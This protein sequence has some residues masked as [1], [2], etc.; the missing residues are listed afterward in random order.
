MKAKITNLLARIMLAMGL[1]AGSAQ[2]AAP[3]TPQGLITGKAYLNITGTALS[4]LTNSTKYPDSPDITLFL[5]YFEWNATGDIATAPGDY[6]DNYGA[7]IAGYFY[8]PSTGD[9]YFYI[10]ADDNAVLYLST[11]SNPANKKLIAQETAYSDAR[12][13][14]SSAGGSDITAKD[15]SQFIGSEWPN[16]PDS[17]YAEIT[18]QAG[19]P[20]YIEAVLKEGTGGDHLAVSVL[21]PNAA[22]DYSLPIPGDYLATDRAVGPVTIV[23]QPASQTAVERGSATFSV[24]AN[25]TPPYT[26]QWRKN[27]TDILDATN[28]S[29]TVTSATIVD[30]NAQFSVV[31]TG[32]EG[33]ATSADAVLTVTPETEPP[34][35]LSAQ[36]RP[37]L[38]EV[39][40]TFSEPLDQTSAT[41][42]GNYSIS[43]S[44]GA[45][46]VT[47]VELSGSGTQV[48][49]T[50]DPQTLGTKYTLNVSNVK[51]TAATPNTI[52]ANSKA[53]F[54]P[55]GQVVE[56][57]GF[58]VLEAENFDRNL[59]GL[60]V[61]DSSRG[62]PSGGSSMLIPN[63]T[64]GSDQT[65]R[66][67]YD[68]NFAQAATYHV[69]MRASADNGND[70]SVW[71][72]IDEDDDGVPEL[73]YERASGN[74]ASMTGFQP[75]ADFVWVSDSQDGPDP[76]T[77]DVPAAG[78]RTIAIARREDG[79]FVD[80][81][82]LTTDSAFT[83]SGVGPAETREGAPGL[84]VVTLT[85]PTADQTF[86]PG[87]D[88]TLSATATGQSGLEI[89]R[90]QFSANGSVIGEATNSPFNLVWTN[91]AAGI[92]GIR[93]TAFDEIGQSSISAPVNI[94][95]SASS[96]A[97]IAWVSFHPADDTPSAG[98]ATAGFTN[99]PD[100]LY[101]DLLKQHGDT[102]T[103]VVTSGTPNT[104]LLNAFD[105]VIISR[106]VPSGDYQDPPET[107]AW[108]GITSP[109]MILGGYILRDSRLG[110]T[111]GSTIPDA[112]G[113]VKLTVSDPNHPIFKGITLDAANTMVNN[114]ADLTTFN[115]KTNR[116]ISVNTD[117]IE[118]GGTVLATVGTDTDPAFGGMI[119]GEFPAGSLINGGVDTLGGHRLVFLTGSREYDGL[120]SE[121]AGVFDLSPD[122][123]KM[124]LNAVDYMSGITPEARPTLSL[125][126][127][128]TGFSLDFTGTLQSAD[129]I[130]GQ[131]N[132]ET[133]AT[134]PFPVTT[135][136]THKFYR[137]K[138]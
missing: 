72:L 71:F 96:G 86:A 18:L 60:W 123:V 43:S 22:I 48:T 109:M 79:A 66:L 59:G 51:D 67:E 3:A 85:S 116:G 62:T 63:G 33:S 57:G 12:E 92:Y 64:G 90:V 13:F 47:A 6:G 89:N 45:L 20:Y 137:A 135:S 23:T 32:P 74:Q 94:T 112:A 103:R 26:Y 136:G 61:R 75:Q 126:R 93:A 73:P 130:D 78:P 118:S 53:V 108:N 55:V 41:T 105:L 31:V 17:V 36:G 95:I 25:G 21:D 81:I 104:N 125:T 113:P 121:G 132:D 122:G 115:T 9:Y 100:V 129:S 127:T 37:S 102:V 133:T 69:W 2:A 70:D 120:T 35:I 91:V 46:N 84:P 58:I 138:Q 49:L 34:T 110:Y 40:L 50:T 106:S 65:I 114:Y 4:G 52:S 77:V 39:V 7:Q 14:F 15:S 44:G 24:E 1:A 117:P 119:I 5:P 101:T 54:F 27:G 30:N 124:F 131:W 10:A 134:S 87:T 16:K 38:S 82:L 107:A 28:I 88:I 80:K 68:V 97:N 128:E 111:I 76:F 19:Q 56:A 8:P 99:A 42:I 83:P 29:Y 11:D 98:A